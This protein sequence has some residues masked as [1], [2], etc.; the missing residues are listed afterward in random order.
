MCFVNISGNYI[1]VMKVSDALAFGGSLRALAIARNGM[2]LT[3]LIYFQCV[4]IT[5]SAAG[6]R[7][8]CKEHNSSS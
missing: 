7:A 3:S 6:L 1:N 2:K 5:G 4:S 8:L